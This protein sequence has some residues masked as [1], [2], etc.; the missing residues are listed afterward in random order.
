MPK[1][2]RQDSDN[3]APVQVEVVPCRSLSLEE[4]TRY[5]GIS[6]NKLAFAS[7]NASARSTL[8]PR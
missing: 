2:E 6:T 8:V 5:V 7:C 3:A 4:A 1:R